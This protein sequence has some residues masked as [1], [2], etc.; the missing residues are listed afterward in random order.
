MS[1][2]V[3]LLLLG[4]VIIFLLL[5]MKF[6]LF[7]KVT[8]TEE[9]FGPMKIVYTTSVGPYSQAYKNIAKVEADLSKV[10]DNKD[11]TKIPCIGIYYD[12]PH[13]VPAEKCRAVIGKIVDDSVKIPDSG[14]NFKST[15]V[16]FG[17]T[18]VCHFPFYSMIDLFVGMFKS[19]PALNKWS[20]D[21]PE[22][23]LAGPMSELYGYIPNKI[24]FVS[25]IGKRDDIL[26]N[27]P[28]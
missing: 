18:I 21:H 19:Y 17:K 26:Q 28:Q 14:E 11:F 25:F 4:I 13:Q 8:V 3:T 20:A 9:S 15:T 2:F 12:N 27:F 1:T 7:H 10:N 16:E 5:A 24:S 22:V 6:H 23:E